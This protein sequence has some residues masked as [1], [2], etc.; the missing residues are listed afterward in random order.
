MCESLDSIGEKLP[1]PGSEAAVAMGCTCPIIDNHY[2]RGVG[3]GGF[4]ITENCPVHAPAY[5][6][7]DHEEQTNG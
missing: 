2:G 1:S 6:D 3:N 7:D 4:W 5:G